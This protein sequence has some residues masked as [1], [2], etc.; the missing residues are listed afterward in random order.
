MG[1]PKVITMVSLVSNDLDDNWGSP[2]YD[3]GNTHRIA[4]N[5]TI[6]QQITTGFSI[7]FP[8]AYNMIYRHSSQI[9]PWYTIIFHI[10]KV[11][12]HVT[13]VYDAI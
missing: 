13:V 8:M 10:F 1:V 12:N 7:Q 2:I 11:E 4:I 9:L 5:Y 3:L 6:L